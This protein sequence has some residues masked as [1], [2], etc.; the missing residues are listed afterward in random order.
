LNIYCYFILRG[1]YPGYLSNLYL[2]PLW[3]VCTKTH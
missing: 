3:R 2:S 1:R